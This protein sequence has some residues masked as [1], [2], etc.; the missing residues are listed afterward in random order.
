MGRGQSAAEPWSRGSTGLSVIRDCVLAVG[1]WRMRG[2]EGRS[3][4]GKPSAR[5][6][7]R[8]AQTV[9]QS[10]Q[11]QSRCALDFPDEDCFRAR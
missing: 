2:D 6:G 1:A 5:S 4:A 9:L 8:G 10:A 3:C 11:K 7:S